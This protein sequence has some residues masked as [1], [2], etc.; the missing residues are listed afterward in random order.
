MSQETCPWPGPGIRADYSEIHLFPP[1]LE[2]WVAADHPARF[3]RAFVDALDLGELGFRVRTSEEGRPNYAADLLLKVWL[4][5]YLSRTYTSRGLERACREH[6]SLIWLTGNH[7]PDHNTL[8]RFWRANKESLRS[9]F[10]RAVELALRW[11]MVGLV[12]HAVDGTKI[13]ADVSKD[14]A[15]HRADLERLRERL[16]STL[17][18]AEQQIEV[19]QRNEL[20]EY[21]LPD[22]LR[23]AEGLRAAI[24]AALARLDEV[25]RDHRHPTDPDARM[26]HCDGKKGFAYNVQAV[27]DQ[28]SGLVVAEEVVNDETDNHRLTAMLEEVEEV[29][30][31]T[32]KQTVADA[33][34]ASGVELARAEERGYEV[35]VNLGEG[36]NP[37]A[38]K[39]EF[40]ASNFRYDEKRDCCVCPR[41]EVLT[42]AGT[43][44]NRHKEYQIRVYR[45]RNFGDCSKRDQCSRS[46]WGRRI[47]IAPYHGALV[48]QRL[49]QREDITRA[50]LKKRKAIVEPVFG[51][52]KHAFGF[53]R[54]TV[55]GLE[56]VRTQ[57]A[58]ICTAYNLRKLHRMWVSGASGPA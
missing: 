9:V 50:I 31:Q 35:V 36:M 57:W 14:N 13:T 5:G 52:I 28:Q 18:E 3:I 30:G 15:W 51:T 2:D 38:N 55:R 33:G 45:C 32:A 44:L 22:K 37:T 42:F 49:K 21:R 40:H 29:V 25:K 34:Y 8:W 46:P 7:A 54:W 20:G 23:D 24:G 43:K 1:A 41:G 48:R 16:D 12:L 27:V 58:L 19:A 6:V 39:K 47:E 10:R 53:R 26:M 4:Y 17:A 56:G 11:E